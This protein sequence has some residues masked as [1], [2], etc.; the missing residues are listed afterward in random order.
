MTVLLL[1]VHPLLYQCLLH[2]HLLT[3]LTH[4]HI[5]PRPQLVTVLTKRGGKGHAPMLV[6]LVTNEQT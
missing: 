5:C 1:S 6:S 4:L 2:L 3:G